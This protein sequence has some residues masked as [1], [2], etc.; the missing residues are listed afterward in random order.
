MISFL[1]SPKGFKKESKLLQERAVESWKNTHPE[2]EVI[3]YGNEEGVAEA[4][5]GLGVRHVPVIGASP[6]GVPRFDAMVGHAAKEARFDLQVYLNCDILLAPDF[7]IRVAPVKLPRFLMVGQCFN[8]GKEARPDLSS[9]DWTPEI[10]RLCRAGEATVRG[11]ESMDYFAFPRGLW[12]GLAPLICGRAGYDPALMAFCLRR[13]IPV[14]DVSKGVRALHQYHDY[15]HVPGG[16]REVY[17]GEEAHFNRAT[18]DILHSS[19]NTADADFELSHGQLEPGNCRGDG[20]R[21]LEIE[22]RFRRNL[23]VP[24]Y[25]IRGLWR[26]LRW[27][28]FG[29]EAE[30]RMEQM[31]D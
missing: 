9:K 4:A 20:L 30:L 19:P 6:R 1:T 11:A 13:R 27:A 12:E 26:G 8:L 24:S 2:A 29:R 3:L 7:L 31:L 5:S 15:A 18:H 21:R 17:L 16:K 28:G 22:L 25:V 23:K 10:R 14:V